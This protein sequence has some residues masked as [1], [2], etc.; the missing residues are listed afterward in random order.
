MV[1]APQR[2]PTGK[3]ANTKREYVMNLLR[4]LVPF[5]DRQSV[6]R[7]ESGVVGSLHQEID[8]LFDEVTRGFGAIAPTGN[9]NL[10]PRIDI[11]ETDN[12]Y[13]ITAEL[14]GLER[15]DVDISLEDNVLTI[16]GEKKIESTQ[17][18]KDK[19]VHVAERSYGIFL[20]MLEL[21]MTV[22]PASVH[23]TMSNGVLKITIPKPARSESKKIEV[24]EE[25]QKAA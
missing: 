23:A 20:R 9:G 5:R 19:N 3:F 16:R 6:A 11:S 14:P 2:A 17:D 18:D 13:V 7:P 15:K 1:G 12:E 8:R 24:K 4:S 22:D 25:T 10:I 21:P